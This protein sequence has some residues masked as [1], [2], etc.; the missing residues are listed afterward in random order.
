IGRNGVAENS[1]GA[2]VHNV[3]DLPDLHREIFEERRFMNVVTLLVPMINVARAGWNFVPLRIL[4]CKIAIKPAKDYR[5]KRGLHGV[6]HLL[7]ARP[8]IAQESFF[9]VFVFTD[10]L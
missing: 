6:A 10:W 8:E 7:W 9:P 1:E 3:F 5:S 4:I 2:R